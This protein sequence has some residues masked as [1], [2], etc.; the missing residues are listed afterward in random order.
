MLPALDYHTSIEFEERDVANAVATVFERSPVR[1]EDGQRAT[2][3]D[4]QT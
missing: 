1:H 4:E 2:Q 3:R